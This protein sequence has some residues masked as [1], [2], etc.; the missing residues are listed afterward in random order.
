MA[1]K[2]IVPQLLGKIPRGESILMCAVM[3]QANSPEGRTALTAPPSRPDLSA[4]ERLVGLRGVSV[5][6]MTGAADR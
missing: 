1:P 5:L 3:A 6:A 4:L 2:T